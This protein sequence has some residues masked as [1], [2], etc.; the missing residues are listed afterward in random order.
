[1]H[2]I[3]SLV[4]SIRTIDNP[5]IVEG[6]IGSIVSIVGSVVKETQRVIDT[7]TNRL[8]AGQAEP[9]VRTLATCKAKLLAAEDDGRATQNLREWKDHI[10][11]LPPIA[12]EIARETKELV[13]RVERA[14]DGGRDRGDEFRL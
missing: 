13:Q 2:S 3:Q 8:L 1:M 7:T 10:N 4:S 14:A 6:K 12:F 5:D 11:V 9:V